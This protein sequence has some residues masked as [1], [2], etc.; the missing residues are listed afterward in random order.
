MVVKS[1]LPGTHQATVGEPVAPPP[2]FLDGCG[3][4]RKAK[5]NRYKEKKQAKKNK[6]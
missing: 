5:S 3:R 1:D 4:G 2:F 6:K